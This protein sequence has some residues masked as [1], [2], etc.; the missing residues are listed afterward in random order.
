MIRNLYW[1]VVLSLLITFSIVGLIE[2]N[3][4]YLVGSAMIIIYSVTYSTLTYIDH[5]R[6]RN[7]S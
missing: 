4:I 6:I 7:S 5:R 3:V 2:N 1:V